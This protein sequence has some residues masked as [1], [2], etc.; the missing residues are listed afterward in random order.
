[1]LANQLV[2]SYGASLDD[3]E[4]TEN[5][6]ME[7]EA[8]ALCSGHVDAFAT[9]AAVPTPSVLDAARRCN[10]RLL[11]LQGPE[12]SDWLAYSAD[13]R[14]IV[15][16]PD[17]YPGIHD[18]TPTIGVRA[19]LVTREAVPADV[20][21]DVVAAV[22]EQLP[23]LRAVH[24]SLERLQPEEMAANGLGAPVHNGATAYFEERGWQ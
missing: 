19:V 21:R 4:M 1:V 24:P 13:L 7:L 22:V 5:L 6:S 11:P 23:L 18:P 2:E 12:I 15:I 9:V 14:E 3:E 20:V 16:P 8:E 10:A 17:V